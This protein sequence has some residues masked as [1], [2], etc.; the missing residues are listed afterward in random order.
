MW[1]KVPKQERADFL[2]R[3]T[4]FTGDAVLYGSFMDRVVREWPIACE[5]NLTDVR[6][7]RLAWIGHAATVLAIHCPEDITRQAWGGLTEDQQISANDMA[8]AALNF[9]V[10][11]HEAKNS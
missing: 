3:A 10:S 5:H 1:R 7:N 8:S 11:E 9:W 4:E 6:Q 2:Q